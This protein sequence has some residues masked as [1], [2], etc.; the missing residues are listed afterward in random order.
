MG[1]SCGSN[2]TLT[3]SGGTT[4]TWS[5]A[6]TL[7]ASTGVSV[8]STPTTTTT[9]T[10]TGTS[11]GCSSTATVTV[12][13]NIACITGPTSVSLGG[14][15]SLADITSGGTWS[16]SNPAIGSI[17]PATG[18][19][20]GV[21]LG[22]A[23]VTYTVGAS[24]VTYPETVVVAGISG[25]NVVCTGQTITLSD[26]S[27]GGTWSSSTPGKGSVDAVTGVVT[28]VAAGTTTIT[29]TDGAGYVTYP[30][31]VNSMSTNYPASISPFNPYVCTGNSVTLSSIGAAGIVSYYWSGPGI[32]ATTGNSAGTSATVTPTANTTYTVTGIN[33]SGCQSIKTSSV[34]VVAPVATFTVSPAAGSLCSGFTETY[35]TQSGNTNYIW[36]ASGT[37][38][39]DYTNSGMGTSSHT[40]TITWLTG[41]SKTVSVNYTTV[42]PIACVSSAASTSN[43]VLVSPVPVFTATP[44]PSGCAGTPYTFAAPS[45]YTNYSWTVNY[46]T[47]VNV[48]SGSLGTS[49]NNSLV[50]SFN[51]IG[52]NN[53]FVYLNYTDPATGCSAA[54]A[55]YD[56]I[57]MFPIPSPTII[58]TVNPVT[59]VGNNETYVTQSSEGPYIWNIPGT[60][61]TDYTIVGTSN[62]SGMTI[63]P[64]STYSVTLKWISQGSKTVSVNY[65]GGGTCYAPVPA[66]ATTFVDSPVATF[67][68]APGVNSCLNN[69]LTFTTQAGGSAYLWSVPGTWSLISGSTS[70]ASN[71]VTGDWTTT[72][73]KTVTV[74]Y[75]DASG[76]PS[77][78]TA[79]LTTS[80]N[81]L[82]V[83]YSVTGGGAYCAGGTGVA[84]GLSNSVVGVNYQLYIGGVSTGSPVAGTGAAISFG[85]QTAAGTC[86]AVATNTTTSCSANM[87]GSV[88][89]TINPLPTISGG[90]NV[91]ICN[92]ANTVLTAS[93][94]TTYTWAPAATLSASIGAS[95]TATPVAT[96]TYTVTGTNVSGCSNTATVTVTVN[97]LPAITSVSAS[98]TVLC[99]GTAIGLNAT[100]VTGTGSPTYSW[101]GPNSFS[102]STAAPS[103]T[104]TTTA[105]SGIYSLTVTY[106]GIGCTSALS[107]TSTVS[108][109]A[110]PTITSVTASPNSL[111]IGAAIGLSAIG[112]TGTGLPTYSW[113]G[114]N[115]FSSASATPSLTAT[116]TAAGGIYSLTVTYP[117]SGC[118]SAQATSSTVTVNALPTITGVTASPN[119]LCVGTALGLSASGVTG[120]GS[121]TY[122]WSG[123]NSFSS[124]SATPSFTATTTAASGIY[125]LTV[126]YPGTGCTSAQSATSTVSINAV[127][128]ITS[129]SASPNP[130]CLGA[131]ISL[132]AT[133]VSGTGS[134]TYSW[135]GP[136]SFSSVS[137]T[138]A[139]TPTATAASGIYSL[140]VTYPG[141]GCTSALATTAAVSVNP[142]P[143]ASPANSGPVCQGTS[144]SLSAD[145]TGGVTSYSWSGPFLSSATVAN[146]SAVPTVTSTYSLTV[147]SGGASGCSP[148]TIY[149]TSVVVNSLP[150]ITA[151]GNS[152]PVCSGTALSFSST[153]SG[154]SGPGTYNYNWS[155]PASFSSSL[156]NPSIPVTTT[157]ASGIYTLT[158]TDANIC[159]ATGANTTSA[160]VNPLPDSITG[161]AIITSP[162]TLSDASAGGTWS[163]SDLT[164]A[165]VGS[166]NGI[167]TGLG[168][169]IANITYTLGTGCYVI[170]PVGVD[171]INGPKLICKG[172]TDT[173]GYAIAGGIWTSATTG[174]AA[175][176]AST[177][178]ISGIS[179]GTSVISYTFS[180]I[181][182]TATVTVDA[183]AVASITGPTGLCMDSTAVFSDVTG[184]GV[185]SSSSSIVSINSS[186]VVSGIALGYV[187]ISY[188]VTDTFSCS[189]SVAKMIYVQGHPAYLY[190]SAGNGAN[191]SLG[192]G[193]PAYLAT[194]QSPRAMCSDTA[195]NIYICDVNVNR[196]RKIDKFGM[197]NTVAG[198]GGTGNG[199]DGGPATSAQLSMSGGGGVYVDRAGNIYISSTFGQTI[200]KVTASTGIISTICGSGIAGYYGDGGPSTA[201]YVRG[202]L[203]ICGDTSGNLYFADASNFRIRKIDS[204]GII[205]TIIGTGSNAYS[206]DGGPGVSARVSV[207]RDLAMDIFGNMY[208]ADF[209]NYVV[210]KYVMATGIITTFAGNGS[211]G[212][213]GDGGPATAASM[214]TPA[215]LAFDGANILYI[216]DQNNNKVRSVNLTT[217][218]INT[219]VAT[220]ISGFAGDGGPSIFGELTSVGGL[221]FNNLGNV[222]MSDISNKRVR[223]SPY[224]G[225]IFT[226]LSGSTS[227]AV[228]TSVTIIAHASL[229]TDVTFQ[230]QVGGTNIPGATNSTYTFN[231]P[232]TGSYTYTCVLTVSPEC[233]LVFTSTSNSITLITSGPPDFPSGIINPEI[234]EGLKVFPNP[235]H[236]ML[237]IE[238]NGFA[239]GKVIIK[240]Y[241]QLSREIYSV[242]S[243]VVDQ[244]FQNQL[245]V[246]SFPAGIYIISVSDESGKNRI[247]KFVKN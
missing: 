99:A 104:A 160:M 205:T 82:P 65:T 244:K 156:P 167:V 146:P 9:Y 117:G 66:S 213:S 125:S 247:V 16:S 186:G 187:N 175:I 177:G 219:A 203:G 52:Y 134:P 95:V 246:Q 240:V 199:G 34:T 143:S 90:S 61:G 243:L 141:A 195:G 14:N 79:S 200:R 109:N 198:G 132:S 103:F 97:A 38:G 60:A 144:V 105:A 25:F 32:I 67:T 196:V 2:A 176:N 111:C 19:F 36:T 211:I 171:A 119:P 193:G 77:V 54:T 113:T 210:R 154:G 86:T 238:G 39:V 17:D 223:V 207:P 8:T 151:I 127:P 74:H 15:I 204:S 215:R 135:T 147:S 100:G 165:I 98:P 124:A 225:S 242:S 72:G 106:P 214:N 89:I 51:G 47:S 3:A 172:S 18:V 6:A 217:G 91:T 163:S 226:T 62:P 136:N 94:G 53:L 81:T 22:S 216:S 1:I 233:G 222:Y 48:T 140:S 185:W 58:S 11:L 179:T 162:D 73:S 189:T 237:S 190:T 201:A 188:T 206:G 202:P 44:S 110:V 234:S 149:T 59:C 169:G 10:V 84:V 123:P 118:I 150:A 40:A 64:A 41:G 114:P 224:N 121:P 122:G 157:A 245:D 236:S 7:S 87:T 101:T 191:S 120:T 145:P 112:V 63:F 128:T 133:G 168:S 208:V 129:V 139:F 131:A 68:T 69:S 227:V 178:V 153:V 78:N 49:S 235:V 85:L 56:S 148:V 43:T 164:K 130:I 46:P 230:W 181:T 209:G 183:P 29:Y 27:P 194:I 20:T 4:Y 55:A 31:T 170:F 24:Y 166:S 192:D 231:A 197:I 115:S 239:D 50:L 28:G 116:T 13:V 88:V 182:V 71:T 221:S 174:V 21:A 102:S 218:I 93:G 80:V 23:T 75:T 107:A 92:G 26:I 173:L 152:G 155:G 158:V 138:P 96:T 142:T 57:H 70:S 228:G 42:V 83:A 37:P 45:G 108:V 232:F 159:S 184:G 76:C 12:S 33:A 212:S 241:D 35:T 30:V 180:G 220:G 161:S 137:A 126:T 5:P 229:V